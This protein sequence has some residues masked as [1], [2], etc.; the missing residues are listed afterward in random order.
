MEMSDE[1]LRQFASSV[2]LQGFLAA[3]CVTRNAM[4]R[5]TMKETS[6]ESLCVMEKLMQ[7][8]DVEAQQFLQQRLDNN[9]GNG[10]CVFDPFS[11][12]DVP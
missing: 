8:G 11:K 6:I 7:S 10:F 4:L 3:R 2:Y 12:T 1:Q 9:K 5:E